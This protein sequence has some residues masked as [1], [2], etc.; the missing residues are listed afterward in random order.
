VALD[1][2]VTTATPFARNQV[3]LA[4]S[5]TVLG[6]RSLLLKQQ[7][8]LGETLAAEPG[9]SAT[10][11]GPGASRPLIRGLGGDRIR[12]LENSVGTLDASVVSPDH[13]VS[14]DPFLVERIEVVHGPASLLYGG[15]AVGGVV[16]VITH[17]IETE[18]PAETVRGGGELRYGSAAD[19]VSVG[20]V[21]DVAHR[22]GKASALVLHLDGS[23]RRAENL[24]IPGFAE[25]ARIRAE[26][27]AEAR[28]HGEPAPD[29]A[30]DRLPNSSLENR[31]GAAGLSW[32]SPA[33][34]IGA[35]YSGFES[36]YGVPGHAHEAEADA[37]AVSE[38]VRIGLRQRRTDLQ[39]EWRG[40]TGWI[41]GARVK[42]GHADYRHTEFEPDG[43]A[44]TVFRNRGH[45]ARAELLHGDGKPWT[46]AFG[47]QTS[48][49][50]FAAVGDEAFLP[51][52]TTRTEALFAFEELA[53]GPVTWQAG[54]RLER[55]R[56]ATASTRRD[57]NLSASLGAVWKPAPE[58]V[59]AGSL[60][61]TG[62]APN[63]QEL[64]ADGPHAGTGSY[65][66]G[67]AGLGRERSLGA[68]VSLRRR[69]GRITGGITVFL[70]RF[71]GYIFEQPTGL[72]AVEHDG[73]WEFETS[74]AGAAHGH[75]EAL[76]V[77]RY[78]ARD[79][80]FHGAEAEAVWHLH[81]TGARQL[82]LRVAAD[83]TRAEEGGRP[84]PR[85]PAARTTVGLLWAAP[86][87][88]AGIESQFV[89]RQ[90]RV[91]ANETATGASA[92]LNAHLART[93]AFGAA[94]AEIFLRG[95]NLTDAEIR[96]HPSFVKELAPL[97]GRAVTG[98]VRFAF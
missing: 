56:I 43:S 13:A 25:S 83:L 79:A 28:S 51:A 87:W 77:Y 17:R 91:A 65:E 90:N 52:S 72:L 41:R 9:I 22:T 86:L 45:E 38:G 50:R 14:V 68:E 89:L 70:H 96:P 16:N 78:V 40:G 7:P 6:G 18:L 69:A 73:K 81:E 84:L 57:R 80:R 75:E 58:W 92:M 23:H 49:S 61:H 98:G 66:V 59:M 31:S 11:F 33:F 35:V 44:G 29:F 21:V 1:Q 64:Y 82:D 10:S 37:P 47:L 15:N 30:R 67:D 2:F 3:D 4:Q 20:G 39:S 54:A 26:E 36:N 53:A 76:P 12:L 8:T 63:A 48:R 27:T 95:T 55:T 88:S 46:G 94:R 71:N 5:T 85:I 19:E 62:R 97:A 32:V 93:V 74:A 24:A 42:F 60:S 34:Q